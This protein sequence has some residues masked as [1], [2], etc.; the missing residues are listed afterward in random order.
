MT[1]VDE[2]GQAELRKGKDLEFE[3]SVSF[4]GTVLRVLFR[5]DDN[6]YTV[7]E[8]GGDDEELTLVGVMPYLSAG[9]HVEG[10]GRLN[11]HPVYG[12]QLSVQKISRSVPHGSERIE[13]YLSSGAVKGIGP[14]TA[15][16]LVEAFGDETLEVMRLQPERVARIRGIGLKKAQ[17]FQG[18]L[19]E[20]RGFQELL[21]L[22]LPHGIGPARILRIHRI[23]GAGAEQQ[24]R[25]NPYELATRVA[26]IGFLTADAIA[27][28]VGIAGDHPARL[29]GAVLFALHQS[30]FREGHTVESEVAVAG[31]LAKK[32]DLKPARLMEAI[33]ALITEGLLVRLTDGMEIEAPSSL[34][35]P[36]PGEG[37]WSRAVKKLA[38]D[39]LRTQAPESRAPA[40]P[41]SSG[42]IALRDVAMIEQ[43]LARRALIL[44]DN[45]LSPQ[46]SMPWQEA[47]SRIESFA[48]QEKFEPGEEQYEA[49]LMALTQSFSIVTGGPGTGKT[50]MVRLLTQILKDRG[51]KILLA[52]PTGRASRRLSEVCK[53][54]AQTL[55]RL[56]ALRVQDDELPDASFWL[57]ADTLDCDTLI[58]DECSMID[59]FLFAKLLTAVK[60]GTRLL[61]I[62]DADQLP[63][64]GPGQVL[65][66]LLQ[67]QAVAHKRLTEIYRQEAHKLIVLN[68]HRILKGDPLEFDQSLES[69]FIFIDCEDE[70]A[71]HEGVIKL[72]RQVLPDYYGLDG[73]WGAQVLSAIRRGAAGVGELNRSLQKLAH[74]DIL[75]AL[76]AGGQ[77]FVSGDKVMQTRN[78]YDLEWKTERGGRRGAGVMNGETGLIQSISLTGRSLEVLFEEERLA[79]IKGEDLNDLDLAYATTI[80]K[81]QGSEYPVEILVIP[82][83]AP[84]FLTRNLLYTGITRA[85]ERL[86]L[87]TRRRTLN[88]M[89]KN[90]EA[91]E[92]RGILARQLAPGL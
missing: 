83:G 32:L 47:A 43:A 79:V 74:G 59:L 11:D 91:N 55:H 56:L 25:T 7:L 27:A 34:P 84:S 49:L 22:L 30:L 46:R 65:R 53:M 16:K 87:L 6:G 67:S 63:S 57:T 51:E 28:A 21:L 71:M 8:V 2:H 76:E 85:K 14:A 9:D 24:I 26:G 73:L 90:N 35:A 81:A 89:L 33:D 62:G 88:M 72:C 92:R 3:K 54:P 15:R 52:A 78:N 38:K 41:P 60:P 42:L 19:E 36:A 1:P 12:P 66:D 39:S 10:E 64:I 77:K 31:A 48:R 20:D 86:F 18:Q 82:S 17:S 58:V 5:N 29:R 80:H 40:P 68:A 70:E 45:K 4:S 50:A 37:I 44:S 23:F 13:K 69:D 75:H 61:L